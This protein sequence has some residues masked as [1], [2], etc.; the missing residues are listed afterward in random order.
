MKKKLVTL[1]VG[2]AAVISMVGCSSTGLLTS[3]Y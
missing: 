1:F 2:L 3:T